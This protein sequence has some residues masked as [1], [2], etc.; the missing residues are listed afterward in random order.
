MSSNKTIKTLKSLFAKYGLPEQIV[1]TDEFKWFCKSNGVRH[2]TG[3]PYHPSTNDA[4]EQAVQTMKKSLKS[5]VNETETI[6][7]KLLRFLISYCITKTE[8]TPAEL[9][10]Q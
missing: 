8:E 4:I 3:A 10:L 2:I 7:T 6:Q 9:L 5:T 1:S